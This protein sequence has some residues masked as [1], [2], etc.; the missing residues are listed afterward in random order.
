MQL[1]ICSNRSERRVKVREAAVAEEEEEEEE[2][3][4]PASGHPGRNGRPARAPATGASCNR[5]VG[6]AT[7]AVA[8]AR[9]PAIASATCSRVRSNRTS[10][11][12]NVPPTTMSPTMAPCTSGLRTTITS[13]PVRSHAGEC[14]CSV[15]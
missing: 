11:P 14:D 9:A 1:P 6:A 5:C 4:D 15:G 12:A 13:S 2:A 7:L 8:A 10:A 3:V